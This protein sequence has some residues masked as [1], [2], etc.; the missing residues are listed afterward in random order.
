MGWNFNFK[1]GGLGHNDLSKSSAS[2][3][4]NFEYHDDMVCN[5]NGHC[6]ES[7]SSSSSSS[8]LL[9]KQIIIETKNKNNCRNTEG[10]RGGYGGSIKQSPQRPPKPE[11][12]KNIN[13]NNNDIN[14]GK[15]GGYNAFIVAHHHRQKQ[16]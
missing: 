2:K 9:Q 6:L 5:G 3:E 16:R 14:T 8:T 4:I 1:R 11:I 13:N 15:G 10:G 7:K 12:I